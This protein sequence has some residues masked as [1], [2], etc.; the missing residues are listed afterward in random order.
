MQRLNRPAHTPVG[1]VFFLF[2]GLAILPAS[3]R[4]AGV[5]VSFSPRLSAV[6]DAWDQMAQ[7]FGASSQ[8]TGD[9]SLVRE[10]ERPDTT[11]VE[12]S[13]AAAGGFV[14]T[15]ASERRPETSNDLP[16]PPNLKTAVARRTSH[17]V[18][19]RDPLASRIIASA[20]V[21][22]FA[23]HPPVIGTLGSKKLET[24][25][26]DSLLNSIDKQVRPNFGAF[27]Q[28]RNLPLPISKSFRVLVHTKRAAV[29]SAKGAESKVFSVLDASRRHECDR[30]ILISTPETN[31]DYSEF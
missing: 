4:M 3:L 30:A 15:H 16:Y 31:A 13:V 9:L 12:A 8:P 26:L 14:C 5:Q 2:L 11:P 10:G 28:I 21:A 23:S 27:A 19:L 18:A 20:V 29:T 7:V 6:I 17:K 24:I 1:T 25:T 22:S